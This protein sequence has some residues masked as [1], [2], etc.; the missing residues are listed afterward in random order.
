VRQTH[1][2]PQPQ[3]RLVDTAA[4][5]ELEG[6]SRR[7]WHTQ[8]RE[9]AEE[10]VACAGYAAHAAADAI[11]SVEVRQLPPKC[12]QVRFVPELR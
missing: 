1:R 5:A 2:E 6:R 12:R 10:R 4:D 3:R 7:D 8:G 11:E 9:G